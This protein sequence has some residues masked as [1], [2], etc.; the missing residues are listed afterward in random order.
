MT[1]RPQSRKNKPLVIFDVEGV[2]IPKNRFLVFELSRKTGI[3]SF[4]KIVILGLL[5]EVRVLSL[6][7]ALEKI[8]QMFKGIPENEVIELTKNVPFMPGTEEVFKKLNSKGYKTALISSGLP[9]KV[10]EDFA[11][12]LQVDHAYGIDLEVTDGL[13]TGKIKNDLTKAGAKAVILKQLLETEKIT[14]EECIVVADDRNNLPM[15]SLSKLRIGYNPDFL[16]TA[17][18]DF[19]TRGALTEILPQ[20]LGE[21]QSISKP[22]KTQPKG[23]RE[24]IHIGSFLLTF[25]SMY[26]LGSFLLAFLIVLV[27][28]LYTLSEIAR[29][30]GV[31]IPVLSFITWKAANKTEL[32]EFATSPIFFALGIALALFVFPEP[33][34]YASIAVL[35]LGDGGAHVFGMKF[36]K[37][38][39]PSNKGKSVE[40][41]IAGFFCAFF[42]ALFFVSPV[43]ALVAAAVGMLIEGLPNPLND[44]LLLP[45]VSGFVLVLIM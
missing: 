37:H 41:T 20:I 39:L 1:V 26:F 38:P 32:Y 42:G 13:L 36:G 10:V 12:T 21:K 9:T 22:K 35:T 28:G 34:N 43:M 11:A 19:I 31:N 2:I 6:E 14:P 25:I 23:P 4:I 45:L 17:K 15:F 3:F 27:T 5:Y 29:I 30:R 40:G 24:L 18:S 8:F 44:N 33:I 7:Y 16:L